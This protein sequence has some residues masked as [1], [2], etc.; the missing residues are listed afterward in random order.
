MQRR[1]S[2]R[3]TGLADLPPK[4]LV[5]RKPWGSELIFAQS[6]RYVGKVLQINAGHRLSLQYH[7]KKSETIY[8]QTGLVDVTVGQ[9]TSNLDI[10]RLEPGDSLEIPA[11]TIHRFSA[12]TDTALLE[13]STPEFND[14]V[15]LEDDYG[16]AP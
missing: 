14:I 12:V 13:V 10:I 2:A 7:R 6:D 3:P 16:R 5:V 8:V 9:T 4:P 15:R 11:T 1:L